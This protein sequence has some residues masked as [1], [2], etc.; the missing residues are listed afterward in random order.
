MKIVKVVGE[1]IH[2]RQ[3]KDTR[4]SFFES[5][6]FSWKIRFLRDG[7]LVACDV[8]VTVGGCV[9]DLVPLHKCPN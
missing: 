2:L 9:S 3:I 8:L 1:E 4:F 6:T 7:V 5:F